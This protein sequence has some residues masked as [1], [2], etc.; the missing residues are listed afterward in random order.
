ML[1]GKFRLFRV[2][3]NGAFSTVKLG[4]DIVT[5]QPVAVKIIQ[6]SSIPDQATLNGI[7]QRN[8][9][10]KSLDHPGIA[11]FIDFIEDESSYYIITEYCSG[12]ELFDFI[13]SR[14]RVE[15]P[16]AKRLFKQIVLT[17]AYIHSQNIVHRDLKPENILL[18]E[19]KNIKIIDFGLCSNHADLPLHDRCGSSCYISP[20]SLTET[21]YYGIPADIWALGVILYTLV[22]GSL[23]WNYQDSNRMFQQITTGD[24]PMPATI[25]LQ[26]QDLLKSIL[27]PNPNTRFSTD[28]I[29]THPWLFGVGNVFPLPKPVDSIAD[30]RLGIGL[31]GFSAGDIKNQ[32]N[33]LQRPVIPPTNS[34]ATIYENPMDPNQQFSLGFGQEVQKP[35]VTPVKK[36]TPRSV[37]LNLAAMAPSQNDNTTVHHGIIMSQTISNRDPTAVAINF[38]NVLISK[39]I[40]YK[41]ADQLFFNISAPG[42]EI[43]AEICRLYGFRNVYV[44]TFNRLQGEGWDYTKFIQALL[45]DMKN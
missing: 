17:V 16:L 5:N 20:E 14:N 42:L 43:T 13:I 18:T 35:V 25:S 41:R 2:I 31:A 28:Q 15:E 38:E 8:E 1:I 12:G 9:I 3:G 11:K 44:V 4:Y 36:V 30:Q 27:N 23:P 40:T 21:Q 39:G 26:C 32:R 33:E 19:A 29:L 7:L 34:L 45:A 10:L 37:S 6:K 24:F 22:D